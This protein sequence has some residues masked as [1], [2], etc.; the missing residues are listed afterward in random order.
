MT[1]IAFDS[2]R[3]HQQ[4][5]KLTP[6]TLQEPADAIKHGDAVVNYFL[7]YGIDF[8]RRFDDVGHYFGHFPSGKFEIVCH[9]FTVPEPKGTSFIFHGYFDHAGLFKHI[10]EYCLQRQCNVVIYDLPGHGLS[11]GERASIGSFIEYETALKDCLKLFLD[12]APQPWHAIAQSTGAAVVMDYLLLQEVPT[13][14]K[15]VLLAPLV[16]AAE[17]RWVK[18]AHWVGQHFLDSVPRKFGRNSGDPAFVKLVEH[19]DPLQTKT[20]PV[21]WV[22]A[23]I[24][25]ERRFDSLPIS[26]RT[27]LILQGQRDVTVDWKYNI[28]A[29]R[30]KFPRAKYLPLQDAAHHLANEIP[31]IRAKI[32]AAMDMYF[33]APK[34]IE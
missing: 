33:E 5:Q 23:L 6:A 27:P 12:V 31:D 11:T 28:N 15:V 7:F 25:W 10:I 8:E 19:D 2:E 17:W 32:F 16:R 1:A 20:I 24:R 3:L 13:F 4:I 9:Y 22:D 14:E 18:A 30:G 29:I 21:A 34:E 26:E